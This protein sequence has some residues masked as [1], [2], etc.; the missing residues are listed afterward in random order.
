[1]ES[2]HRTHFVTDESPASSGDGKAHAFPLENRQS[3]LQ[4]L[5]HACITPVHLLIGLSVL[6]RIYSPA[7]SQVSGSIK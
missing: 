1:M 7:Q 2:T 4:R 6:L 5:G 3:V